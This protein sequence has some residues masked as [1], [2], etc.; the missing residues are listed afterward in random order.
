MVL[1]K[2]ATIETDGGVIRDSAGAVVDVKTEVIG[3]IRVFEAKSFIIDDARATG[4]APLAFV[5]SGRVQI[6]GLLDVSARGKSPGPGAHADGSCAGGDI[7]AV[8]APGNYSGDGPGGGGH[9]TSGAAGGGNNGTSGAAGGAS[10]GAT[11][12]LTGGCRGGN[13]YAPDGSTLS[14]GGGGGGGIEIVSN[15]A[16]TFGATGVVS[17]AGGGGE[18]SA[19]GGSG[20]L[21][22]LEA[23]KLTFSGTASGIATNGG[24]GGCPNLSGKDGTRTTAAAP[25]CGTQAPGSGGTGLLPP[26]MGYVCVANGT[27]FCIINQIAPAGG[28]AGGSAQITTQTGTYDHAASTVTSSEIAALAMIVE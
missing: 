21:I 25:G 8:G 3:T 11:V 14:N 4:T 24:S 15:T 28:G 19:G 9:A 17:A 2:G 20:G 6:T 22:I 23:P 12:P 13:V 5:A 18:P 1:P 16:I 27:N 26:Q 7:H 10:F